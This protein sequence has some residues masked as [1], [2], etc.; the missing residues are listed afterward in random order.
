MWAVTLVRRLRWGERVDFAHTSSNSGSHSRS[1]GT[2]G[3]P[4]SR[5]RIA[6]NLLPSLSR[7]KMHTDLSE[8]TEM[9]PLPSS[10]TARGNCPPLVCAPPPPSACERAPRERAVSAVSRGAEA[11]R[12]AHPHRPRPIPALRPTRRLAPSARSGEQSLPPC[13]PALLLGV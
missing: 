9:K 4:E 2:P 13:G 1:V 8:P 7:A 3:C 5:R 6:N 11:T 12:P 10:W